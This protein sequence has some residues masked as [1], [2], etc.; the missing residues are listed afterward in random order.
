MPTEKAGDTMD[1]EHVVLSHFK[2]LDE[3]NRFLEDAGPEPKLTSPKDCLLG[4]WLSNHPDPELEELHNRFHLLVEEAVR[5]KKLG[6]QSAE[7][8]SLVDEAYSLFAKIEYKLL[9]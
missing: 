6:G 8:K 7:L 9:K 3:V 4:Q 2:Y 1:T 5:K